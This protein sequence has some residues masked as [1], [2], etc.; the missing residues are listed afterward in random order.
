LLV[1]LQEVRRVWDG[2]P[3]SESEEIVLLLPG[4]AIQSALDE[5]AGFRGQP[6]AGRRR[7]QD[8]MQPVDGPAKPGTRPAQEH[9]QR[10]T[11]TLAPQKR[12]V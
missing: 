5:L 11:Q 7:R 8:L 6:Y 2:I 9:V 4:G 10:K 3:Y 1:A 12:T